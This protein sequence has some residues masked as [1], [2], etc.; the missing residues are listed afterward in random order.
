MDE[1]DPLLQST[2]LVSRWS[3]PNPRCEIQDNFSAGDDGGA[4]LSSLSSSF[5]S[6]P[7]G[8][9]GRK[10]FLHRSK[11][12]PAQANLHCL[13]QDHEPIPSK[14]AR[15]KIGPSFSVLKHA[16]LLLLFYLALG[17]F[18]YSTNPEGYLGIETNPVVDALYFCI[19]TLCTIGYGD[20]APLTP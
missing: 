12:A 4:A 18:V 10:S 5:P 11:T 16:I 14:A 15:P 2:L 7:R 20:I 8:V 9:P 1:A 19:V 3:D 17:V 6:P 13:I